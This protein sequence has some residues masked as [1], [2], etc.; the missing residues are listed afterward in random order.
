[1]ETFATS[2][3]NNDLKGVIAIEEEDMKS[4]YEFAKANGIDTQRYIPVGVTFFKSPTKEEPSTTV[5]TVD[6]ENLDQENVTMYIERNNPVPVTKFDLDTGIND[7]FK[8]CK[9]VSIAITRQDQLM[10]KELRG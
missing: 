2:V 1:V 3:D 10:G 9:R 4:L 8:Y 5:I 6:A 7:F